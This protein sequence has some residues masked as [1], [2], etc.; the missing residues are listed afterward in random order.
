[1]S[2]AIEGID[3]GVPP[4]GPGCVECEAAGGW[5][6]HLRRCAQCGHVGCCDTSP[7]QHASRHFA[8]TGHPFIQSFEPGEE[9]FW[10]FR[11]GELFDDGRN[12]PRHDITRRLRRFRAH[13]SE[14]RET[15]R[16]ASTEPTDPS[17][18]ATEV[19]LH[20][21]LPRRAHS[22]W[23]TVNWVIGIKRSARLT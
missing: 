13:G 16:T 2:Q 11:T 21:L 5:W 19:S 1:M 23:A 18:H 12:S 6:V 9:W 14:C 15:G 8:D 20:S 10:N 7:E 17:R 4:S 22:C 3:P